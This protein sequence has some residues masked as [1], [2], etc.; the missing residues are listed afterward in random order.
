MRKIEIELGGMTVENPEEYLPGVIGAA[1]LL[2]DLAP[3]TCEALWRM[4]P[5]TTRTIHT[6]QLGQTWR[7][8]G[9]YKLTESGSVEENLA[10]EVA[11]LAPGN[12]Y[13]FR[14]GNATKFKIMMIYNIAN[15]YP[16]TRLSHIATIDEGLE[17]LIRESR[18]ILYQ[19]PLTVTFR[20]RE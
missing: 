15:S 4:L 2:D 1:T 8:E 13:Y 3:K 10:P 14:P 5:I 16:R 12:I 6:Y 17:G 18:K 7:T 19:G 20:R 9:N 11:R